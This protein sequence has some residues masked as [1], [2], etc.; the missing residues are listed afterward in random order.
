MP[1]LDEGIGPEVLIEQVAL[2]GLVERA[3]HETLSLE[4]LLLRLAALTDFW[5]LI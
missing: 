1:W 3:V 2:L 4:R 5:T